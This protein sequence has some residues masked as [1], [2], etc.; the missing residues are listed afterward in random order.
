MR[1][2]AVDVGIAFFISTTSVADQP[3]G[4]GSGGPPGPLIEPNPPIAATSYCCVSTRTGVSDFGI[5]FF[6]ANASSGAVRAAG[7]ASHA[8]ELRVA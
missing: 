8:P 4:P 5:T 3:T 7:Y 6:I 2:G 1:T